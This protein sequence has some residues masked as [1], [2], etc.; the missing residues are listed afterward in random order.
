VPERDALRLARK[1]KEVPSE[2]AGNSP[3][4]TSEKLKTASTGEELDSS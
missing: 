2:D 1:W 3:G 4:K